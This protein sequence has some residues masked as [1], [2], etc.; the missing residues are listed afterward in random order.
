MLLEGVQLL[1]YIR[2]VPRSNP[3][4]SSGYYG[5]P[6]TPYRSFPLWFY[7]RL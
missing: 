2:D 4:Q 3:G 1:A 7:W 5:A 6:P